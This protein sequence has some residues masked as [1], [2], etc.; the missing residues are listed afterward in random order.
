[1]GGT[2]VLLSEKGVTNN[3]N[4]T[5]NHFIMDKLISSTNSNNQEVTMR[6]EDIKAIK[7]TFT[8]IADECGKHKFCR[9]CKLYN[10]G[11]LLDHAPC[12]INI[13]AIIECFT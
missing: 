7:T 12:N 9:D 8:L 5:I 10:N 6:K 2:R 3:G 11:C 4:N 1:M 13:T